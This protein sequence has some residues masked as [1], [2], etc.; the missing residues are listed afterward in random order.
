MA[1]V[2]RIKRR[3][4]DEPLEALILNCKRQKLTNDDA[5]SEK[6]ELSST[7]LTFAGTIKEVSFDYIFNLLFNTSIC[8]MKMC[9]P[10]LKS[11]I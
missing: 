4:E 11:N 1:A 3:L 10:I 8:R 2:V 7:V 6:T 9:L 5:L